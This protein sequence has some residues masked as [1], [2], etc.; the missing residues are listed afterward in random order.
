MAIPG[1]EEL[2]H[3]RLALL[4][5]GKNYNR[6]PPHPKWLPS[7]S[8]GPCL[9]T[10]L[11]LQDCGFHSFLS[12]TWALCCCSGPCAGPQGLGLGRRGCG[13]IPGWRIIRTRPQQS[14][15]RPDTA[16]HKV[17]SPGKMTGGGEEVLCTVSRAVRARRRLLTNTPTPRP[18]TGIRW[19]ACGDADRKESPALTA[20]TFSS[21]GRPWRR[22]F[23]PGS[24]P[25]E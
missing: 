23:P 8:W 1:S 4:V 10:L 19:S 25:G 21:V 11:L 22:L 14:L 3:K 2:K 6:P 15:H 7:L 13:P 18:K 17:P 5:L 16:A 9:Q 12:Q 24:Q 20:G